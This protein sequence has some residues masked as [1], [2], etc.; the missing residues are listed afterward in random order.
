MKYRNWDYYIVVFTAL[1]LLSACR[2]RKLESALSLSGDNRKELENVLAHYKGD[3]LK[4]KPACFLISNMPGHGRHDSLSIKPLQPYYDKLR[5]ISAGYGWEK[6]TAWRD[7]TNAYW[8]KVKPM[9]LSRLSG[10]KTD[11]NNLKAS[12]LVREID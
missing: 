6:T 7:S 8:E 12:W 5:A 3:E 11:V 2:D 9:A 1:L 4:Y 10:M